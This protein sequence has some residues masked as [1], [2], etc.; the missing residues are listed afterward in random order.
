VP[1]KRPAQDPH[2][3]A[4]LEAGR[5]LDQAGTLTATNLD[6]DIIR[7]ARRRRAVEHDLGN[8]RSL[9]LSSL[10]GP[11]AWIVVVVNLIT[12]SLFSSPT[13]RQH[14]ATLAIDD[15]AEFGLAGDHGGSLGNA[16][17]L[18]LAVAG[19]LCGRIGEPHR[20]S[21]RGA[22]EQDHWPAILLGIG[23]AGETERQVLIASPFCK[24]AH[25][26]ESVQ[27]IPYYVEMAT[28][29]AIYG[30]PGASARSG[31]G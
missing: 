31:S 6:N 10:T 3:V 19:G 5:Q 23:E 16:V 20:I 25:G 17:K 13:Y 21:L 24:F 4:T 30:R 28:R 26:I 29:N 15:P 12:A 11:S 22:A 2:R 8:A 27:R 14:F 7:H 18:Q 1:L 9:K